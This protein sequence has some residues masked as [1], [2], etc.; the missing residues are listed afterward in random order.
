MQQHSDSTSQEMLTV[1][2]FLDPTRFWMF[3]ELFGF[4][5][6]QSEGFIVKG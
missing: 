5:F 3:G 2:M 1:E 4:L 6:D